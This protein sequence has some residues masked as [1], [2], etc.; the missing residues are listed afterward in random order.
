M[1][2]KF[3]AVLSAAA[4]FAGTIGFAAPASAQATRTWISGVGDDANPCSRTAPC[5]TFQGAISKTAAGGE[6][7][8]IDPGGFGAVTITKSIALICDNVLNGV[9]V[10]GT[11]GIIVNGTDISVLLSG[12]D[13]QGLGTGLNGVRFLNGASLHVRNSSIRGF[14]GGGAYG[15][16]FAPGNASGA[17]LVV[18]NVTILDNGAAS[19]V[20]GGIL[21]QPGTGVP[22][23]VLISNSRITDNNR[24]GIRLDAANPTSSI[25]ATI[26][27]SE[28]TDNQVGVYARSAAGGG[29]VNVALVDSVVNGNT[30]TGVLSEDA[31]ATINASGN[32]ISH[33]GNGIRALTGGNLVSFGDNV[34]VS[35]NNNGTFTATATKQ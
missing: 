7:N 31:Q 6:I 2:I 24:G 30:S 1:T 12:F 9:L 15:I 10:S 34:V 4:L 26:S 16:N 21:V 35:N 29:T 19:G 20:T 23:T 33:N 3:S 5:K 14:R 8:C 22:T 11:N 28:I 17:T 32:T 25:K 13:L 27:G 18:D